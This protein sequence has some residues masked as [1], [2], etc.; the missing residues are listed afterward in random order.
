MH[1]KKRQREND[2]PTLLSM[3]YKVGPDT[4]MI[5]RGR[6]CLNNEGNRRF[7]AMVKIELREY[8]AGRKAKKSSIIKR[9]LRAI[10]NSCPLGIGFVKQDALTG[11]FYTATETAAKVT[12]AQAFRD[13]LHEH[14]YKSSKQHKQFKRDIAKGKVNPEDGEMCLSCQEEVRQ[15]EEEDVAHATT[16]AAA[17]DIN[18]EEG[19]ESVMDKLVLADPKTSD[20]AVEEPSLDYWEYNQ[21]LPP[22]DCESGKVTTTTTTTTMDAKPTAGPEVPVATF[23]GFKSTSTLKEVADPFEP[24]PLATA[25]EMDFTGV[26]CEPATTTTSPRKSDPQDT[27]TSDSDNDCSHDT[28]CCNCDDDTD[29][30]EAAM[31][32]WSCEFVSC[33]R[34]SYVEGRG[35]FGLH[36]LPIA[37]IRE[38]LIG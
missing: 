28:G 30:E 11:R 35:D 8:S 12:I 1:Y 33:P 18:E 10:R 32:A 34:C 26:I 19:W 22:L 15:E 6:K 2:A 38:S 16:S 36:P 13:C 9:I 5:G 14:G 37:D 29:E 31:I 24:L 20:K 23:N 17:A 3:D 21:L 27:D 25:M 4:V 7:R